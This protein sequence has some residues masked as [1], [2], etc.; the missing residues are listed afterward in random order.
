MRLGTEN[1]TNKCK[2]NDDRAS[3][4]LVPVNSVTSPRPPLSPLPSTSTF[5]SHDSFTAATRSRSGRP[6]RRVGRCLPLLVLLAV[7]LSVA[8]LWGVGPDLRKALLARCP[9]HEAAAAHAGGLWSHICAR[10]VVHVSTATATSSSTTLARE[11][12]NAD[13][14]SRTSTSSSS[15]SSSSSSSGSGSVAPAGHER[16][17]NDAWELNQHGNRAAAVLAVPGETSAGLPPGAPYDPAEW[18]NVFG[19]QAGPHKRIMKRCTGRAVR[20]RGGEE[21]P[22]DRQ[23]VGLG[24]PCWQGVKGRLRA[25]STWV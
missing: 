8:Q 25:I 1:H 19:G 16:T 17:S 2:K 14:S 4:K 12:T 20:W 11:S 5:N 23:S 6:Q 3:P 18:P 21:A 7:L 22:A 15:V 10:E 9:S 24:W 13:A